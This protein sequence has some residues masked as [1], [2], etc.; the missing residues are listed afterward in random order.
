[1]QRV[2]WW[3]VHHAASFVQHHVQQAKSANNTIIV[4]QQHRRHKSL[5]KLVQRRRLCNL[6]EHTPYQVR[7][8]DLIMF[9]NILPSLPGTMVVPRQVTGEVDTRV[10]VKRRIPPSFLEPYGPCALQCS[11]HDIKWQGRR[12]I[13]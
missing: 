7:I 10:I 6:L 11:C 1:M 13:G 4:R 2:L 12:N 9:V 8:P 5:Y 3:Q